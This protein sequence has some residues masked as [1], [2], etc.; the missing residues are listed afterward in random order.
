MNDTEIVYVKNL[1][2][3]TSLRENRRGKIFRQKAPAA[4]KAIKLFVRDFKK[5]ARGSKR[6]ERRKNIRQTM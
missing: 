6:Y 2:L 4:S 1:T 3:I 5:V